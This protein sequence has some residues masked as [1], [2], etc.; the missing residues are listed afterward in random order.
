LNE[1]KYGWR[2]WYKD[3]DNYVLNPDSFETQ[4][5][6]REA[7]NDKAKEARQQEQDKRLKEQ[8]LAEQA[9]KQEYENDK[10]IYTYCGVLLPFS[11]SSVFVPNRR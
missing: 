4:E 11:I 2:K 3:R 8:Q 10:T 6:Y 7:L 5:D 1:E 9:K